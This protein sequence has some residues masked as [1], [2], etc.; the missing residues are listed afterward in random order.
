MHRFN[1]S[2]VATCAAVLLLGACA[3]VPQSSPTVPAPE[4]EGRPPA[5]AAREPAQKYEPMSGQAGKDV[6]WVPTPPATVEK[7]LDLARVTPDD[8]VMDLGSGDGRNIIAAARRGARALGVEY[9][10]ELVAYARGQAQKAGVAGKAQF[11]EGDMFEADISQATVLALFL[12]PDNLDRL[13]PKFLDLKPGTRIVLNTFGIRGWDAD[14]VERAEEDC[15]AWCTTLLYVVPAKV[16]GR[17]RLGAGELM[18][19]QTYQVV[20]GSYRALGTSR[21]LAHAQL[22]GDRIRFNLDGIEYEGVVNGATMQ[23]TRSGS[24]E[25]WRAVRV[26]G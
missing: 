8:F 7:M 3:T 20:S 15:G 13:V 11:V 12:L 25:S 4:A 18:L 9:N 1:A 24:A 2:L 10:P 5:A 6:V 16:A 26:G 17:W 14:R 21:P 23:G 19:T 22:Q